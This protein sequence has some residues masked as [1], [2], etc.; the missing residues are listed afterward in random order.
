MISISGW[1]N[2]MRCTGE[3]FGLRTKHFRLILVEEQA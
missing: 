2:D 1:L 3:L